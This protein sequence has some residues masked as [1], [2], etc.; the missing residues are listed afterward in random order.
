MYDN[1]KK[2]RRDPII[3]NIKNLQETLLKAEAKNN[4]KY[5]EIIKLNP[6]FQ[7]KLHRPIMPSY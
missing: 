5:H 3:K 7:Y 2:A 6:N 4:A 1:I